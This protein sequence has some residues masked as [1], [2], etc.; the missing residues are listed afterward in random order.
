MREMNA[1]L[2]LPAAA[3]MNTQTPGFTAGVQLCQINP[4][5]YEARS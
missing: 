2:V 5:T 1:A 3:P 4:E